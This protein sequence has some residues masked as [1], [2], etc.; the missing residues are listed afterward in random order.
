MAYNNNETYGLTIKVIDGSESVTRS[1]IESCGGSIVECSRV[2]G[3]SNL[4]ISF[5]DRKHLDFCKYV[6]QK[7][8]EDIVR[9]NDILCSDPEIITP[10]K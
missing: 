3:G 9:F 4:M 7:R 10:N 2:N 6:L 1:V 8:Q 5:G